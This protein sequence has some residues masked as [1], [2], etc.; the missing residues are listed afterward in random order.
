MPAIGILPMTP[1]LFVAT[2][3]AGDRLRR[4]YGKDNSDGYHPLTP[5]SIRQLVTKYAHRAFGEEVKVSP[6][7]LRHTA[8]TLFVRAAALLRRF[9]AS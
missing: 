7:T 1:P 2:T 4:Y 5:E 9:R 8:G 6:H 3:E